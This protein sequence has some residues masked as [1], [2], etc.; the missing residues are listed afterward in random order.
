MTLLANIA[1]IALVGAAIFVF[2]SMRMD[3]GAQERDNSGA[4]ELRKIRKLL[5]GVVI[6]LAV[7]GA[8]AYAV[9]EQQQDDREVCERMNQL[10]GRAS[11]DC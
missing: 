3:A 6:A 5:V 7:V 2:I 1:I 10:F 9:Y 11:E 4:R 8:S